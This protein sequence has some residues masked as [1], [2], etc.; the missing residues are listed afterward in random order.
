MATRFYF[1]DN[2]PGDV[3]PSFESAEFDNYDEVTHHEL[4]DTKQS[5]A[6]TT[7]SHPNGGAGYNSL[8][9]RRYTTNGVLAAQTILSSCTVKCQIRGKEEDAATDAQVFIAVYLCSPD[10]TDWEQKVYI[11]S[12]P[13]EMDT[14]LTNRTAAD[15]PN[16]VWDEFVVSA[17]WRLVVDIG[18]QWLYTSPSTKDAFLEFGDAVESDL[19]E[20]EISTDQFCPWIEFSQDLVLIEVTGTGSTAVTGS[21][22]VKV[23]GVGAIAFL[24]PDIEDVVGSG[25]VEVGGEGVIEFLDPD[26][27]VVVGSGGIEVGGDGIVEFV[28]YGIL[29]V[30]G[31]GG[32]RVG[33]QGIIELISF[34]EAALTILAVTGSGGVVV[35]GIGV[36]EFLTPSVFA[37]VG[38]GGVIVGSPLESTVIGFVEYTSGILAVIGSGGVRVGG[39]GVV[40]LVSLD[41][42][43]TVAV[44]GS[45]GAV[46]GGVGVVE[47]LTPSILE[48]IGSGGVIVGEF[49]PPEIT[50]VG[51]VSSTS[52]LIDVVGSG[53]VE[54]GGVG[55]IAFTENEDSVY[56][57]PTPQSVADA[58]VVVGGAS[59]ISFIFHQI[60]AV[61]GDGGVVVGGGESILP[62]VFETYLMTGARGEPSIYSNFNFNSYAKYRGKYYG[63]GAA[64]IYLLEGADD[65]GEEIYPGMKIGPLNL[66]TNREK[67][68]RI[69]RL[70]SETDGAQVK[71]HNGNGLA[72]YH[73]VENGRADVSMKVEGRELFVEITDFTELSHLELVP[74]VLHKR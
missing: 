67:R 5:T 19:P 10:G 50:V 62:D 53:G 32:V 24:T 48:V 20:D 30:T 17:G 63:A 23:G 65:A 66:G 13:T 4:V 12:D 11:C 72:S 46:V 27:L 60:L 44:I 16:T 2:A 8:L 42:S 34:D 51:F 70:G 33:G 49:R 68:L 9:F 55:V 41:A 6:F 74:L 22:G 40:D 43:T 14:V 3:S 58:D 69:I 56:A 37:V 15:A 54:V 35:G 64:G 59:V 29:A 73:D 39:A 18:I 1:P 28:A 57:V 38:S 7:V 61:I 21:G 25:G 36:V 45:G 47:F 26:V 52:S 71:V 31:Y